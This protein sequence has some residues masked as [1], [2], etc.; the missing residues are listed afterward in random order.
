MRYSR[1]AEIQV[2]DTRRTEAKRKQLESEKE[3]RRE[4][5]ESELQ[6]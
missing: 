1:R 4:R 3:E 6:T 5:M 2:A